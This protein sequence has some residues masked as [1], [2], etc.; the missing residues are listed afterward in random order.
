VETAAAAHGEV[1]DALLQRFRNEPGFR[2]GAVGIDG[3]AWLGDVTPI[4]LGAGTREL[5]VLAMPMASVVEPFERVARSAMLVSVLI[6]AAFVPLIWL[7][8]RWVSRPL[9]KLAASA[10]AIRRF[11]LADDAGRLSRVAEIGRLE[12]ALA[13]MRGHLRTFA[14]YVPKALVRLWIERAETPILG[15]ER[16]EITVL[17]MDLENFTAMSATLTP[18]EVMRRMA[19]YFEV[20]TQTL[21]AHEATID[22]YIGDAVMAFWNAPLD[23][24]DHVAKACRAALAV[25]EAARAETAGWSAAGAPVRTRIGLHC[26]EAIV[27]NVGSSDRMNYTAL[28]AAV[29]LAARLE[30]MNREQGTDVLVSAAIAA[31]IGDRFVLERVGSTELKG[32]ADPVEVFALRGLAPNAGSDQAIGITWR[33]PEISTSGVAPSQEAG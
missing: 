25:V 28:G 5:L 27:G 6:V 7:V 24:E 19:R 22:K 16:R 33:F 32:F 1:A 20:V 30:T 26:G 21:H 18:E 12:E 8:S 31:R 17:F 2:T 29:N 9:V 3:E 13:N 10:D 14:S 23:T 11:E 4:A 15:G